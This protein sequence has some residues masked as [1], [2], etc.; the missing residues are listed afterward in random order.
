MNATESIYYS[1]PPKPGINIIPET[2]C[3][4][5]GFT[6]LMHDPSTGQCPIDYTVEIVSGGTY[7]VTE[8]RT[9]ERVT[10]PLTLAAAVD[11]WNELERG[12]A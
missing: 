7:Y 10:G 4:V 6:V 9:G 1:K 3:D 11:R 8:L 12:E 5:C 2:P